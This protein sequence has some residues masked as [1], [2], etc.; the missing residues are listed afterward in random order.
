MDTSSPVL[1]SYMSKCSL[2]GIFLS[3]HLTHKMG[4]VRLVST[5]TCYLVP[6]FRLYLLHSAQALLWLHL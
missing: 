4:S 6:D 2:S 1:V 3:L 5:Y